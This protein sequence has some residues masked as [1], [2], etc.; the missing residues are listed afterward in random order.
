M[1]AP[2]RLS[3]LAGLFLVAGCS[4]QAVPLPELIAVPAV[5][6]TDSVGTVGDDAADDPAIWRN[7][8][9]PSQSLVIGTDKKAGIYIYDLL[10]KQKSFLAAAAVNNVDLRTITNATG[11]IIL[12]GAS[13]RSERTQ[14][15]LALYTL[16]SVNAK[17][18]PLANIPVG[19]GEAYGFCMGLL[20]GDD[21]RAFIVT[22]EGSIIDMSVTLSDGAPSIEVNHTYKL[23]TQTE[24]CVVD[25]R[26]GKLY[27]GEEN[28]GI[29]SFDL[30]QNDP[31][32]T[33]FAVLK[34]GELVADV[35][36]LALA[37]EGNK[38]G[39]L[40]AS[41]QGD[42]SYAVYDLETGAFRTRFMVEEGVIDTTSDTDGIEL[43]LGDFGSDYPSGI[44]VAQDGDN[45]GGTQ[46]FKFLSWDAIRKSLN[47]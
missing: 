32:S 27:V 24:G 2:L 15:R 23:E 8:A 14:P 30:T 11:D 7:A 17:L 13:D 19:T 26:T 33:R 38:G 34:K 10:G 20:G 46:N 35:E 40:L 43:M 45:G 31:K 9:D 21:L 29:W 6:E 41:S 22:K 37:A 4:K 16:D 36:G 5:S 3:L 42:N 18:S 39:Y 1:G 28:V 25:D 44:F 12:V 47:L